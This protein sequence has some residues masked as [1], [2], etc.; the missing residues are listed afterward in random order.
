[1]M[2]PL[3]DRVRA[4]ERAKGVGVVALVLLVA[5]LAGL[6]FV[7]WQG[8]DAAETDA[9]QQEEKADAG[10]ESLQALCEAGNRAACDAVAELEDL[11][12]DGDDVDP[13]DPEVQDAEIQEPEVQDPEDPDSERQDPETQDAEQQDGEPDDLEVQD[14]ETQEPEVQDPEVDD[15]DPNDPPVCDGEFVCQAE[16]EAAIANFVNA[17]QVIALINERLAPLGCEV[18][19]GGN[20]PPLVLDCTITGKP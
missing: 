8:R 12:D 16:L 13:D 3:A 17:A 2:K 10:Q 9:A 15:P 18:T 14:S 7:Q 11:P 19:V 4:L 20:G 1:M 6:A 5:G